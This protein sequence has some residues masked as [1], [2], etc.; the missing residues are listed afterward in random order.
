MRYDNGKP[1]KKGTRLW[2]PYCGY[3]KGF[4]IKQG[5]CHLAGINGK[6]CRYYR[7]YHPVLKLAPQALV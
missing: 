1:V 5:L 6:G 4:C 2:Y 7:L 3:K